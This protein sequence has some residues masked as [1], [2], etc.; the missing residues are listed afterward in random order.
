[1]NH[2]LSWAGREVFTKAVVQAIPTYAMSI[3]R[4][5]SELCN[6]IQAL[7]NRFWWE[8]STDSRK[9][10]LMGRE[11]LCQSKYNGGLGF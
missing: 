5:P 1:M 3:F 7:I 10:H 2:Y 9:I 11:R 4:F 6:E 8:H